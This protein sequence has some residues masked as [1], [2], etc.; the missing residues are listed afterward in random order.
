MGQKQEQSVSLK[1][2]KIDSPTG[3]IPSITTS[4]KGQKD[5]SSIAIFLK[6]VF[7]ILRASL[8]NSFLSQFNFA[9]KTI[10]KS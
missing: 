6:T 3:S 8:F 10:G 4:K 7:Q 9:D 2:Q 1:G 5:F